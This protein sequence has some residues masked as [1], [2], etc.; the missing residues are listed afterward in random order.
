MLQVK[1]YIQNPIIAPNPASSWESW[2]TFNGNVIR[3][4]DLYHIFYRAMG[5]EQNYQGYGN[6]RLSSVGHAVSKDGF[7][8]TDRSIYLHPEFEW[9]R[10]G[11]EDPR[12][13]KFEDTYFLF[14]TALA[15]NPPQAKG[16]RV[17]VA[18][19]KDLKTIQERHLVTP[20]NAKA[21]ALFPE[22]VNGKIT[23]ILSVNTDNPPSHIAIAQF[24]TIDQI[25]SDSYWRDWYR[26]LN[27]HRIH[28]KRMKT[29]Q[30]EVGAVPVKTPLGWLFTYS[31][32]INYTTAH[33]VFTVEMVMLDPANP[34]HVIGRIPEP[35]LE[36]QE[37]YEFEGI[38]R[39]IVFPSAITVADDDMH[40]Y[41]G[42]TDTTCCVATA[43]YQNILSHFE[44]TTAELPKLIR[45]EGNP[46]LEP[47]AEH[48]WEAKAVFNPAVLQAEN[49]TYILY[50]GLSNDDTST[51]GCAISQSGVHIDQRFPDP[52]YI[53]RASFEMK[54]NNNGGSGC[55]DPRLTRIGD[56][57][58]MCYTAYDGVNN[59]RV[60]LTSMLYEDFINHK[61]IW[62][63]PQL[64]SPPG[65]DDKDACIFEEKINGKYVIFHRI[66]QDIVLDYVD[67]LNFA[68]GQWLQV[69]DV[70]T[71][72]KGWWDSRK[73]G[74][75]A[76]P[77]STPDGWV[78]LY[79]GISEADNEYRVGAMLLQKDHPA[80]VLSRTEFPL[81]EPELQFE[82]EGI[83]NN[84][85]FPCGAAVI[86]G[87]L[88]VY[89]GGADKVVGLATIPLQEL[90]D[91]LKERSERRHLLADK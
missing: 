87:V 58:Y 62:K 34:R 48:P 3:D 6:F 79:H 4:N 86:K 90:L 73:I 57:V 15:T 54:K 32:I 74:I 23:A 76:P 40:I 25:W 9:E 46:L 5:N 65:M 66:G 88:H 19:S 35:V 59:P 10:F 26:Q 78:L 36:P 30:V 52:V 24:D 22:R 2:A 67:S 81:L 69:R 29:D 18:L 47:E 80:T 61:W 42:A 37:P 41:Y 38:V 51:V 84:V 1:R 28:L 49:K 68:E 53:P 44:K 33:P 39:N 91:Y 77:I 21:M 31:Y 70:I 60:A 11:C 13:T 43:S 71:P 63:M 82:K 89:Y 85:V 55:E 64:I 72:R 20:F 50:R 14:Y 16:I 56:T 75:S 83:V 45:Y 27:E 17:G 8:F 7:N 12:M